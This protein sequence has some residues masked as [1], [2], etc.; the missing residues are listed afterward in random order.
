MNKCPICKKP[1]GMAV[2]IG[3]VC[4]TNKCP[5]LDDALLWS[6]NEKGEAVRVF[7][8]NKQISS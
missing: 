6:I 2:G 4:T 8:E 5:V 7:I 3:L 1:L